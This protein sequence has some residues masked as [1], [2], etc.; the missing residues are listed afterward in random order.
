MLRSAL[1]VAALAGAASAQFSSSLP[2]NT[3]GGSVG[4]AVSTYLWD[5]GVSENSVGLTSGGSLAWWNGFNTTA[6]NQITSVEVTFG[7]AAFAGT[8]GLVGGE[9]LE[10][11][12]WED[13]DT[14][15]TNGAT[16]L[17]TVFT[18]VNGAN[19]DNDTFQS[20][21][22]S[23]TVGQPVFWIGVSLTHAAGTF[24]A[25]LDAS[26][27]SLGRSWVNVGSASVDLGSALEMDSIGIP[28]V[29]M[30]RATAVPAPAGLAVI[31][32]GGLA[33]GRRRR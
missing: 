20:V 3:G 6:N 31:G 21:A 7:T 2:N 10:V 13:N 32:L 9:A 8:S 27:P 19:I 16:L 30:L 23:A 24:P 33:I 11:A 29:W 22:I 5:D 14:N 17:A 1:I 12:V 15:P 28:G 18:T 4:P 25:S 26:S